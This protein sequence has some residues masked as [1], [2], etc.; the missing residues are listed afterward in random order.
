MLLVSAGGLAADRTAQVVIYDGKPTAL[1]GAQVTQKGLWITISDLALATG[2]HIK[3][4]GVC[5]DELCFP[6]PAKRKG[7]FISKRG[8]TT[9]F[10]VTEFAALIK[11]PVARDEKNGVWYFGPRVESHEGYRQS[12]KAP[13][14]TLPD[15]NGKRHSLSEFLGKKVLLVTWAS[16]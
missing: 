14:F 11:Q 16:W 10:N 6:I 8:S 2:F 12:L 4:Q 9:W 3:P 1:P 7:E 5:K 13:D 15:Q